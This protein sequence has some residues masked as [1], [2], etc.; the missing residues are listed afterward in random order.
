MHYISV[1]ELLA[2]RK[3]P[4]AHS[5]HYVENRRSRI[6]P[7]AQASGSAVH[8]T[9]QALTLG[10]VPHVP[11]DV[12]GFAEAVLREELQNDE[13]INTEG[14]VKRYLPGVCNAVQKVPA[15][16]WESDWQCEAR[17]DWR[18]SAEDVLN[19]EA[20][21][22]AGRV[23]IFGH[24]DR[25]RVLSDS[26]DIIDLKTQGLDTRTEPSEALL[27]YMLWN[28][29]VRYYAAIL[30][31]MHPDKVVRYKYVVVPTQ[32]KSIAD[33]GWWP[34]TE[35]AA[36]SARN[37]MV[38]AADAIGQRGPAYPNYSRACEYCEY[39]PVCE[40]IIAGGDG[41]R[42]LD[43]EFVPRERLVMPEPEVVA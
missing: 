42:L 29:Q 7:V 16:F 39:R 13:D 6:R 2:W 33:Y 28:P 26:V 20:S 3:C 8:R 19:A 24:V 4:R 22:L 36:L 31:A 11:E 17:I 1:S 5:F 30:Q 12:R 9:V 10:A 18:P 40:V 35:Q 27:N 15:W 32:T 23:D 41:Y 43:E 38:Q 37:E 25:Y 21:F 34:L 14:L